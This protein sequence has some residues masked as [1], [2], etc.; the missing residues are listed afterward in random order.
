ME[1]DMSGWRDGTLSATVGHSSLGWSDVSKAEFR[2][3]SG[4]CLSKVI[5]KI[6]SSLLGRKNERE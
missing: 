3:F 1:G 2:S 4:F 6:A 5:G